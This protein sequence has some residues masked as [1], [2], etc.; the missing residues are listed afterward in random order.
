MIKISPNPRS[1]T[2]SLFHYC[3]KHTE[4]TSHPLTKLPDLLIGSFS[5]SGALLEAGGARLLAAR[6]SE[7]G[8]HAEVTKK[9]QRE[10]SKGYGHK[11][12]ER[13]N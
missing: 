1:V 3:L 4:Y 11:D 6:T 8:T 2:S 5:Q 10:S 7:R 12:I 9:T 13:S